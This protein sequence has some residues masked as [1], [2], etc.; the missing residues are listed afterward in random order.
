MADRSE[1]TADLSGFDLDMIRQWFNA[2]QD[3]APGYLEQ[4]D[5]ELAARIHRSLHLPVPRSIFRHLES[6]ANAE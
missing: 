5:F 6:N 2:V 1:T 4:R 3:V